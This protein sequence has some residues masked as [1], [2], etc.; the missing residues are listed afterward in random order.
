MKKIY[1]VNCGKYWK[2]GKPKISCLSEKKIVLSIISSEMSVKTKMKK[3]LN[4]K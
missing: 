4:K 1:Y 2:F 3:H